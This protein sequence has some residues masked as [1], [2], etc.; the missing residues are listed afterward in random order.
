MPSGVS[1]AIVTQLNME[2]NKAL[3]SASVQE[4]FVSLG[5]EPM[6]GTPEMFSALIKREASKWA[7]LVK[8]AN[9]KMD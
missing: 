1:K 7:V 3:A 8:D 2:L 5:A 6:G 4:K 9:I